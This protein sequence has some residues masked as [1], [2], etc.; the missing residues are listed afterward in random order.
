M[1]KISVVVFFVTLAV[2]L[3]L[4]PSFYTKGMSTNPCGSCHPG[5]IY[6]QSLD[7]LEGNS[8]NQI[9]ADIE[10]DETKTV[11][12]IVENRGNSGTYSIISDVSLTLTT[13]YGH[14]SVNSP[15]YNIDE[16]PLG[17]KTATWQITGVSEGFD[18]LIITANGVNRQH[19]ALTFLFSDSYSPSASIKVGHPSP[20]PPP[21]ATPTPNPDTEPTPP[22]TE[23]LSIVLQSPANGERWVAGTIYTMKWSTSGGTKPLSITLDY[24]LSDNSESW[25]TIAANIADNGSL[26]WKTPNS[27]VMIYIRALVTDSGNPT[28]SAVTMK[29]VE[30]KE[31]G[32]PTM[33]VVPVALSIVAVLVLVLIKLKK[34]NALA[35]PEGDRK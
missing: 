10:I 28:Q 18:S 5:K 17:E 32:S 12:V 8:A 11:S 13:K 27:T 34:K 35:K 14:F 19:L 9:P 16:L 3:L 23:P 2:I 15:T 24:S 20:T 31:T 4:F 25:T 26:I 7:I 33:I 30:V 22:S 29:N 1:K 6:S 21:K